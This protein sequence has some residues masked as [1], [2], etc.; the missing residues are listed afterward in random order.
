MTPRT[1]DGFLVIFSNSLSLFSD[2]A[3]R[4]V[5]RDLFEILVGNFVRNREPRRILLWLNPT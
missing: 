5:V 4:R 2:F 1:D 3:G